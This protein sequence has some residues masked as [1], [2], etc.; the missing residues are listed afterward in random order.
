MTKRTSRPAA[1]Q[2]RQIADGDIRKQ[3]Y[4]FAPE[5][6]APAADTTAKVQ[7]PKYVRLQR[8]RRVLATRLRIPPP[9]NQF[10]ITADKPLATRIFKFLDDL[11][12]KTKKAKAQ[13]IK[14]AAGASEKSLAPAAVASGKSIEYGIKDVTAL[15]EANRAKLVVIAND[16][17]PIEIVVWLPALCRRFGTPFVI[18][19]TKARLGAVVGLSTTSAIAVGDVKSE[20]RKELQQILDQ[21]TA[22]DVGPNKEE[23]G[24]WGGGKLSE[25]TIQKLRQQGK[26]D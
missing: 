14:K 16:V 26:H 10:N 18:V 21:I 3:E 1:Q 15:V 6:A 17:E 25:E 12:P 23:F 4:L 24:Q 2:E 11:K 13:Q 20:N 7:W 5:A 19:K 9:V 8:Q 22:D